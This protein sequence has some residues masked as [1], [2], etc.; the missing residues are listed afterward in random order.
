M[1]FASRI[2]SKSSLD[3]LQTDVQSTFYHHSWKYRSTTR[4]STSKR[5]LFQLLPFR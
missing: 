2:A 1:A 5:F 3:L 4:A